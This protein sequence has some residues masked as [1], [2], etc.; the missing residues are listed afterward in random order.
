MARKIEEIGVGFTA[1]TSDFPLVLSVQTSS[2]GLHRLALTTYF[3][4]IKAA[5]H[6]TEYLPPSRGRICGAAS[7]H[8]KVYMVW[9]LMQPGTF[10][11][12][13][14]NY[15]PVLL[16]SSLKAIYSRSKSRYVT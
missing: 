5:G 3:L 6:E 2:G 11:F 15:K 16:A 14:N 10:F 13:K 12:A 9:C 7:T 4:E 1:W 8:S